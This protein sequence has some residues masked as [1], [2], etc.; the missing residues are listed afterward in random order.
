MQMIVPWITPE[1]SPTA[2]TDG[3]ADVL[4][5]DVR[6]GDA[7]AAH[8]EGTFVVVRREQPAP[9]TPSTSGCLTPPP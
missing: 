7:V 3:V 4:L 2:N 8:P 9:S 5:H 1:H 6:D